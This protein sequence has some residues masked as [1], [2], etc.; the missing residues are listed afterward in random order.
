MSKPNQF[1]NLPEPRRLILSW[2]PDLDLSNETQSRT[3]RAVGE[4]QNVDGNISFRYLR[5]TESFDN[6]LAEGFEDYPAYPMTKTDMVFKNCMSIFSRRLV[7]N[8]RLDYKDHLNAYGIDH[9]G[10]YSDFHLLALTG[11]RNSTDTFEFI[12]P[13]EELSYG[14][15]GLLEVAGV[16]HYQKV[17]FSNLSI[18]S[19]ISFEHEP[20][21]TFD[22]NAIKVIAENGVQLGW[23]NRIQISATICAEN[24]NDFDAEIFRLNGRVGYRRIFVLFK[25]KNRSLS[26]SA[27]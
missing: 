17:D 11:G 26:S 10:S 13:L 3:R 16:R 15:V 22:P 4:L 2:L 9:N 18:G 19:A 12:N 1:V 20:E 25:F 21:N 5:G 23:I 8:T 7:P 14:A 24:L 27:A 6:A